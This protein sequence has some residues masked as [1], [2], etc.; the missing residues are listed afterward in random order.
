MTREEDPRLLRGQGR[1][2]DDV[3]PSG[4]AHAVLVR[5]PLAHATIRSIEASAANIAPG[6]LAVLTARELQERGLGAQR[7]AQKRCRSDGSPAFVTPQPLLAGDRVRYVG[8]PVALIVAETRAKAKDA[9]ELVDVTY[10]PLPVAVTADQSMAEGAFPIWDDNPDNEAFLFETGDAAATEAAIASA[11]HVVRHRIMMSRVTANSMEPRGCLSEYDPVDDHY[12]IRCTV[13]SAHGTRAVLA[14]AYFNK[15]QNRFRVICDNMGGGFGMKGGCYPEYAL[16]LWAAEVTGRPVKWIAE[17]GEGIL[18]DE[19]GRG[20]VIDAELALDDNGHF[21]A[22]RVLSRVAIGA[23]YTTDR[24]LGPING[25]GCLVN[26]YTTPAIHARVQCI[27]T[28]TMTIAPYR[29]GGRPEPLFVIEQMID[30]AARELAIDPLELRRRNLIAADA[31]PYQTPLG[32]TYDCGDFLRNLDDCR[33]AADY[34]GVPARRE[35]ARRRGRILGVGVSTICE[36]AAGRRFEHAEL[37]F[38]PSGSLTI[39]A[40]AMDHGQGHAT[41]FKQVVADRLGIGPDDMRYRYG[42]TDLV[43]M[44]VGTSGSRTAVLCGG[45]ISVAADRIVEKAR[46]IAA[47]HLEAAEKDIVFASGTLSV[48]GTDRS[49]SIKEI[50]RLSFST[51]ALPAGLEPGLTGHAEFSSEPTWPNG[52]HICEVEIE[53]ETGKVQLTRY[54]AVDDVGVMLNPLLVEGQI[55]GGIAQGA[56]QALME[57]L[58]YDEETGQLV[59]GS[60]TDYC[61]PRAKDLCAFE[62]HE[63]AIPT[64]TNPLGVKGAGETGTCGALPAVLSAVNDALHSIGAPQVHMPATPQKVWRAIASV[65]G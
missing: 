33:K 11:H 26:S 13:Q 62:L 9:A 12:T 23:Y 7:P 18:S 46:R 59:T 35:D 21:T 53:E 34:D 15:P 56:G 45:A 48:V 41:T 4:L 52:T 28:N 6:V 40:G 3:H 25:I 24:S 49:V 64:A 17:R 22:L 20:S 30:K 55:I 47:H 27:F 38:D 57:D 31:M 5:S 36:P 1:F 19:Q 2:A 39:L 43:A 58:L 51:T 65:R 14:N 42:D 54:V 10:D 63:N 50:A 44:G 29:G 37:R 60:F 32:R 16:T 8:Q 61:M